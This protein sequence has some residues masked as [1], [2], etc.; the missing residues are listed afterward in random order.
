MLRN[1][2]TNLLY[3]V[4]LL[5]AIM[6]ISIAAFLQQQYIIGA[7]AFLILMIFIYN[8]SKYVNN[9]NKDVASFLS[10]IRYNDFTSNTLTDV[11][12]SHFEELH[13]SFDLINQKFR[14]I[15]AEKEAN[16]QFLQTLVQHVEVGLLGIDQNGKVILINQALQ[17]LLRRSYISHTAALEKIDDRLW[18]VIMTL[19]SGQRELVKVNVQ[20]KLLQL[21]IQVTEITL[22]QE[23]Y[24]LFSFQ[25]IQSEL[26]AQ[27]LDSWQK[28]IRTLTHEIMNSVAP[29]N[30]LSST[31]TQLMSQ[32]ETISD[33]LFQ[34]L[35]QSLAVIQRRSEGLMRFTETYRKLTKIPLPQFESVNVASLISDIEILMQPD[36]EKNQVAFVKQL[37]EKIAD[38]AAD[39]NLLE[40]VLI[41]LIKNS[42]S[43]VRNRPNPK[44]EVSVFAAENAK[45]GIQIIDNGMGISEAKLEQI[46]IPFYTTKEEGSGIGLSLSL[47]IIQMHKGSLSITSTEDVGTTAT[48]VI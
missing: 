36:F 26:E 38:I 39:P 43:A 13:E 34:Q 24:R 20:N 29:I 2:T 22:Q 8:L 48:I 16:Y 27:E 6:S 11:K 1:F 18:E 44:I 46:F 31:L 45:V 7:V 23:P 42:L 28:L 33:E 25:N 9:T 17:K 5:C 37:P 32:Q 21:S 30:S 41:N 14:D 47:Q 40:Q 3:R 10:G 19:K 15:R 35:Q 4:F 12:G